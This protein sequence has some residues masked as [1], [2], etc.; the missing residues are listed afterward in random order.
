MSEELPDCDLDVFKNG[1]TVCMIHTV[2][3]EFIEE[4]VKKV[5]E[6]S[7]AKVDWSYMAGRAVVQTL[8]DPEKVKKV[9]KE[10]RHQVQEAYVEKSKEW[11]L[12]DHST[13]KGIQLYP[14]EF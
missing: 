4:W 2:P 5:A 13:Y 1:V 8:G 10:L 7:E 6:K 9:I 3:S 11:D 12:P 14:E